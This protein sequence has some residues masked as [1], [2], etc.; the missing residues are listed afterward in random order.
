MS[1][2]VN[3]RSCLTAEGYAHAQHK[4]LALIAG[5]KEAR[6]KIL[7]TGMMKNPAVSSE[8]LIFPIAVAVASSRLPLF[9][10]SA[11]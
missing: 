4:E 2:E 7:Q 5:G 10:W 3:D 11:D 8:I 1:P 6:S 9:N